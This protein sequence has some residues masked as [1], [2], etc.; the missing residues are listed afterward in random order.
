MVNAPIAVI[1]F[2]V[3]IVTSALVGMLSI[4]FLLNYLKT[5]G[6]GVFA[7]YRVLLGLG[8][9]MICFIRGLSHDFL[10]EK[11]IGWQDL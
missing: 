2:L 10:E 5:K 11:I 4:K 6:F 9:I 7:V 8:V 3:A 1:P